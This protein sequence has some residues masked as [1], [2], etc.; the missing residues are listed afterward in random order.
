[1]S[2]FKLWV[3]PICQKESRRK[4]IYPLAERLATLNLPPGTKICLSC[5]DEKLASVKSVGRR[6]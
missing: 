4:G 1:M 3:C 5:Y 2:Q 6:G